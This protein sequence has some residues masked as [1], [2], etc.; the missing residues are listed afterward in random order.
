MTC[1]EMELV[2]SRLRRTVRQRAGAFAFLEAPCS[3]SV[4]PMFAK[5]IK[6]EKKPYLE[7]FGWIVSKIDLPNSMVRL[8]NENG[9][10]LLCPAR[11]RLGVVN[12]LST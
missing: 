1:R 9:K 8:I 11:Y 2:G 3:G 6:P 7:G 12:E 4:L 5:N 10:S